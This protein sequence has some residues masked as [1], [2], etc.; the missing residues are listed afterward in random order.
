MIVLA[1]NV[2]F[3]V[4]GAPALHVGYGHLPLPRS[5]ISA[6][7]L[8][9]DMIDIIFLYVSK[10]YSWSELKILLDEW[11]NNERSVAILGDVNWQFDASSTD[12]GRYLQN[13]LKFMLE[14]NF[15]NV[16]D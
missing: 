13:M 4:S 2:W 6:I 5:K 7:F 9:S 8:K 1:L 16:N 12:M 11:I 14:K 15:T 10:N 3:E